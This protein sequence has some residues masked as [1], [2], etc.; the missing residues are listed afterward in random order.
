MTSSS[1]S[2]GQGSP[3]KVPGPEPKPEDL[4]SSEAAARIADE[5]LAEQDKRKEERFIWI[6]MMVILI[7][8]LWFKDSANPVLPLVVLV[9]QLILLVIVARRL[10]IDDVVELID[11]LLHAVGSKGGG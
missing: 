7:D 8:V 6:T 10:G 4:K 1:P 2:T 11:R 3:S 5:L 9:F